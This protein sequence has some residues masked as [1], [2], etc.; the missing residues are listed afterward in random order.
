MKSVGPDKHLYFDYNATTPVSSE[1]F[2][3]LAPFF[4][5]FFGNPSSLHAAGQQAARAVREARKKAAALLGMSDE[6]QI[7]F[8][9]GGTEGNTTALRAALGGHPDLKEIV[10]SRVEHSSV[11]KICRQLVKEGYR[12][13]EIGVDAEGHLDLE[14]LKKSVGSRTAVASFMLAN[15]E[16][17]VLFPVAEIAGICRGAGVPL[18]LDAIQAAG[19]TDLQGIMEYADYVT[20]SGHKFYAPK[21][22]GVLAVGAKAPYVPLLI[23][24]S[25]ERGRRGGTENVPGIVGFGAA[26]DWALIHWREE[27]VRLKS[28]RD[29]FES[30][31]LSQVERLRINGDRLM[32]LPNTSNVAFEG[33][34]NEALLVLLDQRG[35]CA[36]SGSACMSGAGDP[37]HVLSAMGL[38]GPLAKSSLRFSFGRWTR[39]ED[40]ETL[41]AALEEC[42]DH[43]RSVAPRPVDL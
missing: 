34:E 29:Q 26:C 37:S 2:T 1:V 14:E 9:S 5:D 19:K 40:I 27:S 41:V 15:N 23:G 35:L 4:Q 31:L 6:R 30:R 39:G 22:I 24:G 25:Q 12:V 38:S 20:L 17:G 10:T 36:S 18:H 3:A 32:R 7:I 16:T 21:G 42:T 13:R 28:L 8:T 33:I 43:L 11:L